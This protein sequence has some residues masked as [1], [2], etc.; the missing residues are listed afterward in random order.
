MKPRHQRSFQISFL[1]IVLASL[2]RIGVGGVTFPMALG[3][4]NGDTVIQKMAVDSAY[5]MVIAGLCSDT[6]IV[7]ALN[8]NFIM[9]LNVGG[10]TWLWQK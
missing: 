4:F 8:T 3:G 1:L 10:N 2:L 9:Y 6:A 7:T 5:N